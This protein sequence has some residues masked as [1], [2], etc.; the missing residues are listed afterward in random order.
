MSPTV[1]AESALPD[2]QTHMTTAKKD[3]GPV[4]ILT[5]AQLQSIAKSRRQQ[6]RAKP[7]KNP[8]ACFCLSTTV[9]KWT[10]GGAIWMPI[11]KA[12]KGVIVIQ[13]LPSG[14]IED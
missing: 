4:P 12:E 9:L 5:T 8:T 11:Y 7:P 14:N 1:A 6:S 3:E 2:A 10:T 13:S